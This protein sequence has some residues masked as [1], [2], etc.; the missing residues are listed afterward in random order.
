MALG[1][2][3]LEKEWELLMYSLSMVIQVFATPSFM[4]KTHWSLQVITSYMILF[5]TTTF[6]IKIAINI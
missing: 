5:N 6:V 2:V 4:G 3:T 1:Q